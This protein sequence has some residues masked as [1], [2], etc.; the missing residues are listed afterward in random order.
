MFP[1]DSVFW[2]THEV[3]QAPT[4]GV[5]RLPLRKRQEESHKTVVEEGRKERGR[6]VSC[7]PEEEEG[8]SAKLKKQTTTKHRVMEADVISQLNHW[9]GSSDAQRSALHSNSS[10]NHVTRAQPARSAPVPQ[11]V[12]CAPDL[13]STPFLVGGSGCHLNAWKTPRLVAK[14][15]LKGRAAGMW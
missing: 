4:S 7:I 11:C 6:S 13:R 3:A 9:R 12:C 1:N 2:A 5:C 8:G 15:P 10:R 14:S